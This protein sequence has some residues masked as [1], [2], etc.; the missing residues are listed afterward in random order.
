MGTSEKDF[1]ASIEATLL[2]DRLGR[3]GTAALAEAPIG[4]YFPGGYQRREPTDYDKALCLV[5]ND[6]L[7]ARPRRAIERLAEYRTALISAAVT[8]QIDVRSGR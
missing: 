2:R 5:P 8:G 7:V 1:E 3:D 4:A 6:A